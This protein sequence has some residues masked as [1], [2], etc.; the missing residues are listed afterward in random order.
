MP[1]SRRRPA[2]GLLGNHTAD[3]TISLSGRKDILAELA[4][5]RQSAL[6]GR[7]KAANEALG[8]ERRLI[9][10]LPGRA[11][12]TL[13]LNLYARPDAVATNVPMPKSLFVGGIEVD[14]AFIHAPAIGSPLTFA[15]ATYGGFCHISINMDIGVIARPEDLYVAARD[16]LT[17][18]FGVPGVEIITAWRRALSREVRANST[19]SRSW[20]GVRDAD[21]GSEDG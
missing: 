5:A 4:E 17:D 9:K 13:A 18:N 7:Q 1:A 14:K 16:E 20:H 11:Q 6:R 2:D 15:I 12:G 19:L 21:A 3:V 8:F 10:W